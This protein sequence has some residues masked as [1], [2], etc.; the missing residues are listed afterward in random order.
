MGKNKRNIIDLQ[1][2]DLAQRMVNGYALNHS[3]LS[4]KALLRVNIWLKAKHIIE[5]LILFSVLF[6][7]LKLLRVRLYA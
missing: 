4:A 1:S 2:A 7:Y 6:K 5:T 3:T